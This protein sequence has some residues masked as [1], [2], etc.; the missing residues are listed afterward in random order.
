[1]MLSATPDNDGQPKDVTN[2]AEQPA[3]PAADGVEPVRKTEAEWREQ[4]PAAAFQVL[5]KHGT[6]RPNSSDLLKEK[7]EGVYSCKGCGLTLFSSLTKFESGTGWPS[8]YAPLKEAHLGRTVDYK[9]GYPRTEVHCAACQGHLGHV[10]N[11]GP[12][13]TGLRYC[14]N[15]VALTFEPI[16][17]ESIQQE[18][19]WND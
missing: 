9:I 4:L 12:E 5:R 3:T 16:A 6:E 11:D 10:F 8:F 7:R 19:T 18:K 14:I 17:A 15:G 1:M 13:P 2:L